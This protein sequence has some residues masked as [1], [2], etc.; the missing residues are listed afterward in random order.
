MIRKLLSAALVLATAGCWAGKGRPFKSADRQS[1]VI[2][3]D[4]AGGRRASGAIVSKRLRGHEIS[5]LYLAIRRSA[6]EAIPGDTLLMAGPQF[7]ASAQAVRKDGK[8][9]WRAHAR[10]DA[11]ILPIRL[12]AED[13]QKA[14]ALES[15]REGDPAIPAPPDELMRL[16]DETPWP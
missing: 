16:A 9:L 15:L 4:Q 8:P 1:Q 3:T 13:G 11:A 2:V 6:L 7:P 14:V 10:L 12:L 5:R